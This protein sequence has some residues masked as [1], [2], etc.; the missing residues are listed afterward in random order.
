MDKNKAL[1]IES[2]KT[3]AANFFRDEFSGHDMLHTMRVMENAKKLHSRHGGDLFII[4]LAA[5]L[6]DFDDKK[7]S[8]K[9][10]KILIMREQ[11]F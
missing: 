1:I 3:E 10:Q 8:P 4:S 2:V 7:I 9:T 11:Y 5:L 6:H